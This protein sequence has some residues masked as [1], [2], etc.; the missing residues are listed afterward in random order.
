M[1]HQNKL[2]LHQK[3][4][5]EMTKQQ[6]LDTMLE[7]RVQLF[8][9]ARIAISY[10]DTKW[11][12]SSG[13]CTDRR[14]GADLYRNA[15]NVIEMVYSLCEKNINRIKKADLEMDFDTYNRVFNDL[16]R[17]IEEVI[18]PLKVAELAEATATEAPEATAP[19]QMGLVFPE[20]L[21]EISPN[22]PTKFMCLECGEMHHYENGEFATNYN[23]QIGLVC[24]DCRYEKEY[25]Q[26]PLCGELHHGDSMFLADD[27][28]EVYELIG[29]KVLYT[30][31]TCHFKALGEAEKRK[32]QRL[33]GSDFIQ[34]HHFEECEE[35]GIIIF[36]VNTRCK[37]KRAK[38][39]TG[40]LENYDFKTKTYN[41]LDRSF[42]RLYPEYV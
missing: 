41:N 23:G 18:V 26:C 25:F 20:I 22:D 4:G 24:E 34:I 30:C 33:N 15:R 32:E 38:K 28:E 27:N 14:T 16:A 8:D 11:V 39:F 17:F 42:S 31:E 29:H 12:K 2:N 21:G 40:S 37:K 10:G 35:T 13:I 9:M 7:K 19:E 1:C 36:Y 3:R 6:I 5:N